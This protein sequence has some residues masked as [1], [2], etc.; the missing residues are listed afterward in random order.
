[1]QTLDRIK[2]INRALVGIGGGAIQTLEDETDAAEAAVMGYDTVIEDLLSRYPWHF[3]QFSVQLSKQPDPPARM[4]KAK[5]K[6]APARLGPPRAVWRTAT[7][8]TPLTSYEIELDCLLA[9]SDTL[10]ATF[11]T[12]TDP[13]VWPAW[14]RKLAILALQSEYALSIRENIQLARAKHDEAYGPE[15][16]GGLGGQMAVCRQMDSQARPSPQLMQANPLVDSM[17]IGSGAFGEIA[18]GW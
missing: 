17:S 16:Y 5:F 14:F 2:L 13:N 6:M 11:G 18:P 8:Q 9:D 3:N 10:F 4:W 7:D 1:M 15:A 12:M